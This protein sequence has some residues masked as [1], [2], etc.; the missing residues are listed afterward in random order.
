M[1]NECIFP[2]KNVCVWVFRIVLC[3]TA[4]YYPSIAQKI[5][6]IIIRQWKTI[7]K[8]KS[9]KQKTSATGNNMKNTKV[10]LGKRS[11]TQNS[12]HFI[13]AFIQRHKQAKLICSAKRRVVYLWVGEWREEGDTVWKGT[14]GSLFGTKNVVY[15]DLDGAYIIIFISENSSSYVCKICVL[16]YILDLIIVFKRCM[17][18]HTLLKES[19]DFPSRFSNGSNK[20]RVNTRDK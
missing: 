3:I 17:C 19:R 18:M 15:L 2:S 12:T 10:M 1:R 6:C 11:Q 7:Q 16:S 8:L 4:K 20:D 13:I 14:Q 5:N 9:K